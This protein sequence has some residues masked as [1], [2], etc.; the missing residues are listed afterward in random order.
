MRTNSIRHKNSVRSLANLY[1]VIIGVSLT[2][3]ITGVV[4]PDAGLNQVTASSLLLLLAFITTLV[5]FYHGALRHL[6]DAYIENPTPYIK[7]GLLVVDI[8]LLLLHALVFVLLAQLMLKPAH[9]AWALAA[10]LSIDVVWGT[11]VHFVPG[12]NTSGTYGKW[13]IINAVFVILSTSYLVHNDVFL[14]MVEKPAKL[15][16]LLAA[17]CVL[18]TIADYGWC[19]HF[20]FPKA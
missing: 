19:R 14:G 1:T 16:F 4:K 6:D 13:A 12:S 9:F 5:P 17:A 3:A 15:A 8:A 11:L 20:Y 18:R 7:D 10:L 2:M